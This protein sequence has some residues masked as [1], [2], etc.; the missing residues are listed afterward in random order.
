[1]RRRLRTATLGAEIPPDTPIDGPRGL[2]VY[3]CLVYHDAGTLTDKELAAGILA[4]RTADD[5]A[6][7]ALLTQLQAIDDERKALLA[8]AWTERRQQYEHDRDK[9]SDAHLN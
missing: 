1:M 3:A 8:Q 2:F 5:E 7:E 4:V 6:L 9:W